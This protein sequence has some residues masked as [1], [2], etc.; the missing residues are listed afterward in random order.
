MDWII[1]KMKK[2]KNIT[3][4]HFIGLSLLPIIA[5]WHLPKAP[6]T[7][8]MAV[9]SFIIIIVGVIYSWNKIDKKR[10]VNILKLTLASLWALYYIRLFLG[11]V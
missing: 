10:P 8:V 5:F 1:S 9:I 3:L 4:D 6:I 7:R 2:D 11:K